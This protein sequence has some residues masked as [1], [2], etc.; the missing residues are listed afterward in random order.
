MSSN[1]D[2]GFVPRNQDGHSQSHHASSYFHNND[3]N[4]FAGFDPALAGEQHDALN[5][6][7]N[8]DWSYQPEQLG[9][10]HAH[11]PQASLYQ[12]WHNPSHQQH[13]LN[14]QPG[15]FNDFYNHS[16]QQNVQQQQQQQNPEPAKNT[17]FDGSNDFRYPMPSSYGLSNPYTATLNDNAF[18]PTAY[19]IEDTP[20]NTISPGA[21]Q[22]RP[23]SY[24]QQ[25]MP[26]PVKQEEVRNLLVT[27][28]LGRRL[29]LNRSSQ[30]CLSVK[31]HWLR[32]NCR[33]A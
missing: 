28:F 8:H 12:G 25:S 20:M 27:L 16:Y 31:L 15:G 19:G 1:A 11:D 22:S 10:N 6:A 30:N 3:N 4:A 33:K 21:L 9:L 32:L 24:P 17:H 26:V 18:Q 2:S 14:I 5:F 7:N 23:S 13:D 29:T